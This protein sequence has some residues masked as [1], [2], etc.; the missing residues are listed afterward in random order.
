[1]KEK[2]I[3]ETDVPEM[4]DRIRKDPKSSFTVFLSLELKE[5]YEDRPVEEA[6]LEFNQWRKLLILRED[7]KDEAQKLKDSQEQHKRWLKRKKQDE[8]Q[9]LNKKPVN[10]PEWAKQASTKRLLDMRFTSHCT[11]IIYAELATREHIPNKLEAREK[12]RDAAKK[13]KKWVNSR[14]LHNVKKLENGST[15]EKEQD[16]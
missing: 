4:I 12:R 8:L 13:N 11:E 1:M 16:S 3:K 7:K 2:T 5:R 9:K 14:E 6:H 15:I 10:I